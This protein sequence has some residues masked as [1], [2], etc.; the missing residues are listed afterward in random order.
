[1]WD[2]TIPSNTVS[3]MLFFHFLVCSAKTIHIL[4]NMLVPIG[5]QGLLW[6]YNSTVEICWRRLGFLK[7]TILNLAISVLRVYI[8]NDYLLASLGLIFR[9][10]GNIAIINAWRKITKA[11]VKQINL[12]GDKSEHS[13]WCYYYSW[14]EMS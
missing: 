3:H 4:N 5:Y 14:D 1:M 2:I 7:V 12:L 13:G 11:K 9:L 10:L 6:S 8:H